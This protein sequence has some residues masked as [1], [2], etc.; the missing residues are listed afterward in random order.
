MDNIN[1]GDLRKWAESE[2]NKG[3]RVKASKIYRVW[4]K[5][6]IMTYP[7]TTTDDLICYRNNMQ[8]NIK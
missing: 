4:E 2:Y 8:K 1:L 7:G 3:N 5:Y 6:M